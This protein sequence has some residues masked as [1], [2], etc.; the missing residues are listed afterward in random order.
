MQ[1]D[2]EE[3]TESGNV[4]PLEQAREAESTTVAD[5]SDHNLAVRFVSKYGDQLRHVGQWNKWMLYTGKVWEVDYNEQA[6]E[7]ARKAL[8]HWAMRIYTGEVTRG[9]A[10]I[11]SGLGEFDRKSRVRNIKKNALSVV[12]PMKSY[13]T[14][15]HVSM[16]AR[17][18]E[19]IIQNVDS[20]DADPWLLNTPDGTVD[21]KTGGIRKHNPH[22][23]M[24]MTTAVGPSLEPPTRWIEFLKQITDGDDEL[25][26]YFQRI[27]GYSLTGLTGEHAMFFVYGTGGNGKSVIL[28]TVGN[29]LNTYHKS[30]G[31]ETF[32]LSN[33]SR[34][35]TELANLRGA[36]LVTAS[37]TQAG[38]K[39]DEVKVKRLT[40]GDPISARFMRQDFFEFFPQFKLFVVGNHKP[41]MANV[42]EAMRR[43][44]NL[45][46][47]S[48]NI[49]KEKQD[50]HLVTK[51]EEEWPSI[52]QWMID[53]CMQWQS[54][55]LKAPETVRAATD[56]YMALEDHFGSWW[57]ECCE[58]NARGFTKVAELYDSWSS[59]CQKNTEAAGGKKTFSQTLSGRAEVLKIKYYQT[60]DG[61][62]FRGVTLR[63]KSS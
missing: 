21:L 32:I 12:R 46:S 14:I 25:I 28:N 11:P 49:P 60:A 58:F 48:V 13:R 15:H 31:M 56:N 20:W 44:F 8:T 1:E 52:L 2:Q 55:G 59:W 4:V 45:I 61:R 47:L 41:H 26:A 18:D 54:M 40:G 43:R 6:L 62:G 23:Y 22:D 34:H 50:I 5:L 27:L 3:P 38:R 10:N 39:W 9:I 30:S 33:D 16:L 7:L 29:L 57:Q 53:G 42:D 37:E 19:K 35:P 36:R 63:E 17:G 24:T 51:L